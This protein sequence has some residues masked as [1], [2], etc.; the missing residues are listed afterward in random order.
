VNGV[1]AGHRA[2]QRIGDVMVVVYCPHHGDRVLLGYRSIDTLANTAEGVFL[3]WRCWC[4]ALGTL[5]TGLG[6][7]RRSGS[8]L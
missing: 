1:H 5:R 6:A 8:G 2:A 4:G 7:A 3:R